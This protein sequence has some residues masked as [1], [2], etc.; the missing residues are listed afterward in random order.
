MGA[1]SWKY[2]LIL[3]VFLPVT[4]C[5]IKILSLDK[6]ETCTQDRGLS[7]NMNITEALSN[8][9][10]NWVHGSDLSGNG[11]LMKQSVTIPNQI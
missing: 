8:Q 6:L 10:R 2:E 7:D 3:E 11:N 5:F 1:V 4:I 9:S